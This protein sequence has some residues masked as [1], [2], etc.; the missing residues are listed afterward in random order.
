MSSG[1]LDVR[2]G[3]AFLRLENPPVNSLGLELR[4]SIVDALARAEDDPA[5]K[6]IVLI[7]SGKGFSGGADIRE[8][9]TPK[10]LAAPNL[11][12]VLRAAEECTKPV[13]AAIDGV[14]MGGGVELALAC[15]YR[16]ATP[17][18]QIALPEVKLGL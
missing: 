17:D 2:D 5:V 1:K 6:A 4:R 9:G 18:A 8:F 12:G 3:V 7:G 13:I 15:H 11:H 10:S 16:I 14:C